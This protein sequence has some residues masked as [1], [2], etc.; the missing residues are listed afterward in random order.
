MSNEGLSNAEAGGM[1]RMA[2]DTE[3]AGAWKWEGFM[4]RPGLEDQLIVLRLMYLIT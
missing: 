2:E 4:P 3:P 1:M